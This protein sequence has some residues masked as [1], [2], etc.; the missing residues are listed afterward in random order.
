VKS[1]GACV[2]S[3]AALAGRRGRGVTSARSPARKGLA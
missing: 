2:V 1:S 3:C